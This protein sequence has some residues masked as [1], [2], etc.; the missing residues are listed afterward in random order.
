MLM[1]NLATTISF[2]GLAANDGIVRDCVFTYQR[3]YI[4]KAMYRSLMPLTL[5]TS[6]CTTNNCPICMGFGLSKNVHKPLSK[7]SWLHKSNVSWFFTARRKLR[8]EIVLL[9]F[10]DFSRLPRNTRLTPT[11]MTY[12][13]KLIQSTW[14]A[15]LLFLTNTIHVSP[16]L[17]VTY[18]RLTR[19][20]IKEDIKGKAHPTHCSGAAITVG[21]PP[22]HHG[23]FSSFP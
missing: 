13:A 9:Q 17:T 23:Y 3:L 1:T 6:Y 8:C 14:S 18:L 4:L 7:I 21:N 15:S 22:W 20:S 2:L 5:L 12:E 10:V 19:H 11:Q 16:R